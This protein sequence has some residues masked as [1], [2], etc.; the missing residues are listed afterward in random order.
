MIFPISCYI[1]VTER[2]L[3][4]LNSITKRFFN[5][6]KE[7]S[8]LST[9]HRSHI[10]CVVVEGRHIIATGCNEPTESY[11]QRKYNKYRNFDADKYPAC[12]HA[13][14]KALHTVMSKRNVDWDNVSI[15][16]YREANGQRSCSRPCAA[17]EKL[18]KDLG[19]K[20]IYYTDWDGNYCKEKVL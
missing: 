20:N 8:K 7:I 5:I 17:C 10:G 6:A 19:I 4:T 16:T 11:I 3:I 13:E 18:I 14:I 12:V 2:E 9:F 1:I 15:Y